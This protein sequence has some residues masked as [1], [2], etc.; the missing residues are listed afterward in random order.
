MNN[1]HVI[2]DKFG[3]IG[4]YLDEK[5]AIKFVNEWKK[6][7]NLM[8]LDFPLNSEEQKDDIYFLP[9]KGVDT[10]PL[11]LVTNDR[12]LFLKT[13]KKLVSMDLTFPD[14]IDFFTKKIGVVDPIEFQRLTDKSVRYKEDLLDKIFTKISEAEEMDLKQPFDKML[15]GII[16]GHESILGDDNNYVT[17]V[18]D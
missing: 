8:I 1:I 3:F 5:E 4:A 13:Q 2:F 14:D 6:H 17:T 7:V 18:D 12:T 15:S 10:F 11:A 16:S 9:W